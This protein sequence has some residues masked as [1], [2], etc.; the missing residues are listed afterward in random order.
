MKILIDAGANLEIKDVDSCT[1]AHDAATLRDTRAL[2]FLLN[3][4]ANPDAANGIGTTALMAAAQRGHVEHVRCLLDAEAS[5]HG[6]KNIN[7]FDVLQIVSLNLSGPSNWIHVPVAAGDNPNET[8]AN[9]RRVR[10]LLV[11]YD[12]RRN[13]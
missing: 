6:P 11:E 4:G 1:P 3:A 8:L 5:I 7:G 12:R 9:L 13:E 10:D 2:K